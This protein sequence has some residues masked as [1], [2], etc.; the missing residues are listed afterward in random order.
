VAG[1]ATVGY[2][3]KTLADKLGVKAGM[4]CGTVGAPSQYAALL[5]MLPA[6]VVLEPAREAAA[7]HLV[8]VFAGDVAALTSAMPAALAYVAPGGML[9]ISWPKKTSPLCRDLTDNAIRA[10][11][12]P[13]GWVDVKVC[14]VDADWSALKFLPRKTPK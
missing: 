6:G 5:G 12:L 4:R 11:V 3:G 1:V 9:W 13:T 2:S 14:A 7:Y 8:H 10:A